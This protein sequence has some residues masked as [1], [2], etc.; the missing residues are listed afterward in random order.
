[1]K[2]LMILGGSRYAIPVIETAHRLGIYVITCDYLPDN[3]AHKYSDEYCNV[4]IIDKEAVL[5]AA[6]KLNIDGIMSFACDPGVVTAAY[7]AERMGLPFQCPYESAV[8]LQDKGL[9]RQFLADNAFNTPHAKRYT[10]S[11]QPLDD[12]DFFTW[13]VIVKPADSA[14]SKGVTKVNE[15]N[16]LAA[17]IET[18]MSASHN[19]AF[20][21]E[22]FLTFEGFHSSTDPFTI[23]GKLAFITYSDHLFDK[24]ADNPYA[25]VMA[26][27][28]S[29]MKLEHQKYLTKET[30]RLLDLL[31]MRDG[32]Y[33]IETC[34]G[35]DGKAYIMEVSPRGGGNKIAELQERA[36]GVNLIENE[37][38]KAVRLPMLVM[39]QKECEG[40][41]C[42][43]AVHARPG[44]SGVLNSITLNPEIRKKYVKMIDFSTKPGDVIQPFTGANMSLGNI[45]LR[46]DSRE[47]LNEVMSRQDEW[48]HI[49]LEGKSRQK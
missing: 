17:A 29:S 45:F 1:M 19:G 34:V 16:E 4:S 39:E 23:N 25:P 38:R 2:K 15:P 22:D 26:V 18:A 42:E 44:Q 20:I 47:E 49:E 24:A 3:I 21:I 48:L 31:G 32:I 11:R 46:F 13:P 7:V 5:E 27:W 14:G 30:Q 40:Y 10:D 12:I 8:I 35:A 28:P 41:W 9:F 6:E 37:V 33:N 43:M 36:F